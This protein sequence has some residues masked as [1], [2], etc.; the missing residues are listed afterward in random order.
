MEAPKD[1]GVASSVGEVNIVLGFM[2]VAMGV[3]GSAWFPLLE[4][5]T[6]TKQ[7]PQTKQTHRMN[8]INFFHYPNDISNHCQKLFIINPCDTF[9]EL[10]QNNNHPR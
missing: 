5:A 1:K 9:F 10:I 8:F 7:R 4:Q 6:I 2:A 3:G